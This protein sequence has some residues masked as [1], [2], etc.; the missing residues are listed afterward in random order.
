MKVI[1]S[2]DEFHDQISSAKREA[3]KGFNDEQLIVEKLVESARHIEV[4][5]LSD[6]FGNFLHIFERDCTLQ[7]RH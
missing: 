4:Q 3:L 2:T 1:R 6:S 7:R 5:I